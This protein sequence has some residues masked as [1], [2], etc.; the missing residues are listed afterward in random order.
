LWHLG[1]DNVGD[2]TESQSF[3]R[4]Q[5]GSENNEV[6]GAGSSGLE[7][8]DNDVTAYTDGLSGNPSALCPRCCH[9]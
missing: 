7:N 9:G 2:V 5:A 6:T 3:A 4:D 8:G 1:C